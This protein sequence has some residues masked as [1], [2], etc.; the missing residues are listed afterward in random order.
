MKILNDHK[1]IWEIVALIR[2][3]PLLPSK[4]Y[5]PSGR[6][7]LLNRR[8]R[9]LAHRNGSKIWAKSALPILIAGLVGLWV[10]IIGP[11]LR[12]HS[13]H[14][15]LTVT[16]AVKPGGPQAAATPQVTTRKGRGKVSVRPVSV[17]QVMLRVAKDHVARRVIATVG[18]VP[19]LEA[20]KGA[21]VDMVERALHA[22]HFE[23]RD[24]IIRHRFRAFRTYGLRKR[25]QP[26]AA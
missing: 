12:A 3:G 26:G 8:D 4:S 7:P 9:L 19:D 15:Q 18:S 5:R 16:Q 10:Q 14:E 25:P 11:E 13:G 1:W 17:G 21:D 20:M 24:A 6:G 22:A 2:R 23:L